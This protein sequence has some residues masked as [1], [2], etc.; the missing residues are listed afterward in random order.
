M[1]SHVIAFP[2]LLSK[3]VEPSVLILGTAPSVKSL[4]K[5]QYYGHPQNAFWWIMSQI[6]SFD[7]GLEYQDRVQKL[8]D[9]GVAVWDVL[10]SCERNGSLDSDIKVATEVPNKI[11]ELLKSRSS[12][13]SVFCNGGKALALFKKHFSKELVAQYGVK[14]LPSTSPAHASI[15]REAKLEKWSI[16]NVNYVK[17]SDKIIL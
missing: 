15:T 13:K 5:Q 3:T 10:E 14:T 4:E 6:Y 1:T 9:S 16:I 17:Q 8:T 11:E 12:I 2:K 7:V